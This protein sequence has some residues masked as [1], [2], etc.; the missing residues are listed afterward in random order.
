MPCGPPGRRMAG[1]HDPPAYRCRR[2]DVLALRRRRP[3]TL[4]GV[5][6]GLGIHPNEAAKHV[7]QLLHGGLLR[8]EATGGQTWYLPEAEPGQN[9]T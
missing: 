9:Q 4:A 2:D 5:A 8:V 6:E 1:V 7:G 3:C